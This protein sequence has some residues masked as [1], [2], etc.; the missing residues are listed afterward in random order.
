M[1][2]GNEFSTPD[3]LAIRIEEAARTAQV[4]FDL[5]DSIRLGL[6]AAK[7]AFAGCGVELRIEDKDRLRAFI[8]ETDRLCFCRTKK[9]KRYK[10]NHL[11]SHSDCFWLSYHLELGVLSFPNADDVRINISQ[12]LKSA[13]EVGINETQI[14][15]KFIEYYGVNDPLRP[16]IIAGLLGSNF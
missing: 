4:A 2:S 8:A 13:N 11:D 15:R 10:L 5:Y 3:N 12:S 9:F 16:V 6:A 1:T 14:L 7:L